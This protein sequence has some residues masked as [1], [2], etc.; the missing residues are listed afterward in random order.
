LNLMGNTNKVADRDIAQ[1]NRYGVAPS[2]ALGL[3]TPTRLVVSYFY[4]TD[5]DTP[6]FGIPWYFGKPA[7]VPRNNY[8]GFRSDRERTGANIGTVRLD[9]DFFDWLTADVESRYAAYGRT[10]IAG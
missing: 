1:Y 5:D 3:G 2:L 6:D 10:E 7:P 4:Q 8:Y 9:H